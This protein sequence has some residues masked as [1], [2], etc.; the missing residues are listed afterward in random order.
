MRQL[1]SHV[2]SAHVIAMLALFVAM[3]GTGYA[4]LKLPK[5]S[6]GSKQ[7]KKNAVTGKKIKKNSVTS[8]KV[9][10]GS[11]T[12]I[13]FGAGQLPK[14]DK[15]DKGGKGDTGPAGPITGTLPSGVTLRGDWAL[16]VANSIAGQRLQTAFS[17]GLQLASA[18]TAHF[19][20]A[21]AA[22]PPGCSGNVDS[23]G[24]DPGNLCVFE[25]V[26]NNVTA[27]S[28]DVFG[29]AGTAMT[30]DTWGAGVG[31]NATAGDGTTSVDTRERGSWAVTAP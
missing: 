22:T 3:G 12:A 17:F 28:Q 13:D 20:E 31:F 1:R 26:K 5:N 9:K 25:K 18:P 24:A 29:I 30:A 7:I 14:G 21:G 15:G 11:L 10:D 16:R 6:V 4:A 19:I 23:P 8:V 27:G 2:T